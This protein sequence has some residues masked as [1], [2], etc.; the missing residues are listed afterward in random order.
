[1]TGG[2]LVSGPLAE[3]GAV[4][5]GSA[6]M[7]GRAFCELLES[8]GVFHTRATRR[9]CDLADP[10][11]VA[12]APIPDRDVWINCA[13]W[14]DVDG[15]EEQED[16]AL[17]V[18]GGKGLRRLCD[19]IAAAKSVLVHFSTD[20]VFDGRAD[21]PYAVDHPREPINAYGRTKAAGEAVIESSGCEHLII[22]TSWLY[23]PW[24]KNFMRTIARRCGELEELRVVNDQ[25]GR[26]SSC[27]HLAR[28]T[29][30]LL[31]RGARGIFHVTDGGACTW[32]EFAREI[33]AILGSSCR[34][35]PC[36]TSEYPR[37]AERPAYSVLDLART[38]E[39]ISPMPHWK[40]NLKG[41]LARW[42]R[43]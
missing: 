24:G 14:T 22:R 33:A 10:E 26:P 8:R 27:E 43:E 18:N 12:R 36:P 2:P 37:P 35:E 1:M 28:A 39:L 23:A 21:E 5:L 19:R 40:D 7:L 13:A 17:A 30:A 16:A 6:G 3:R 29:L 42:E 41:V 34:V 11:S 31:D 20:Y 38:E 32:H 9:T 25:E 15:A 4:V